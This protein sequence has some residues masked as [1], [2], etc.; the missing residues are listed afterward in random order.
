MRWVLRKIKECVEVRRLI[1]RFSASYF[2]I[3]NLRVNYVEF[4]YLKSDSFKI[5]DC[6]S[7]DSANLRFS[8]KIPYKNKF[9]VRLIE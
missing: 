2:Q 9:A 1:T 3:F 4:V 7:K 8:L 5:Y 6:T